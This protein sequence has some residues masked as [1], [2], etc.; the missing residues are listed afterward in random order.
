MVEMNSNIIHIR[1]YNGSLVPI[2]KVML[3]TTDPNTGKILQEVPL[4]DLIEKLMYHNMNSFE[5]TEMPFR[6]LESYDIIQ[7][8][9]R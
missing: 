1:S 6:D 3:V 4:A 7:Q 8:V 5:R 2:N 9:K